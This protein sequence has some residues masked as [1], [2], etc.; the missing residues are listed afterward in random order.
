MKI[1]AVR[2]SV[3]KLPLVKPFKTALRTALEIDNI[4]V[5]VL[6]EDGTEGI[7]AAAPTVAITGDSTGSIVEII[8]EVIAPQ[9]EGKEIEQLNRLS[10]I[11]QNSSV[12]NTS[13]KAAVEIALYDAVCK[14]LKL[15]LYQFIGGR[16]NN[17][18][19]DMTVSV[20]EPADMVRDAID[21]VR[22][23]FSTM[24]IKVG[25]DWEKDVERIESIRQ[26]VGADITIR[27][28]A[29][30][31]WTPKQAIK[32]IHELENRN[33]NIDLI[34]QPVKAYDIDGLKEIKNHV[35][36]PI[37]ADES[38]FSPRDAMRLLSEKA[39]DFLNIKLMKTGGIRRALQIADMAEAAEVECMIG[40]M[41]ESSVSV[42]AAAHLATAHPNITKIDLDA[43][44]WIKDEPFE[45][46]QY[47]KDQLIL[48]EEFGLGVKRKPSF[49][50]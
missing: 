34:E 2:V 36:L 25:K 14:Q 41:M 10:L 5:S 7:G 37:M 38:L 32:I 39:V 42:A 35:E 6:L 31:G 21:I 15:P 22:D 30:Q 26:A 12:G 24:K 50:L 8:S 1:Q 49:S 44:L 11:V 3:E 13:A 47:V 43:P 17:L 18:Q 46:I 19:N 48:S 27:V 4:F 40:S 29:N 45:G 28:D 20:G 33:L 9:L 23:G 16:T